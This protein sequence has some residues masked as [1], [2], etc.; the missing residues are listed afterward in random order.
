MTTHYKRGHLEMEAPSPS[1]QAPLPHRAQQG[2]TPADPSRTGPPSKRHCIRGPASTVLPVQGLPS[3]E[4]GFLASIDHRPFDPQSLHPLPFVPDALYPDATG[5]VT[6][7][8][9][10]CETGCLGRV[11][12]RPDPPQISQIPHLRLK[13]ETIRLQRSPVWAQYQPT[14][15]HSRLPIPAA[16][17]P[18]TRGQHSGLLGRLARLAPSRIPLRTGRYLSSK[19]PVLARVPHQRAQICP[20]PGAPDHLPRC[21][22]ER[23]IG[24]HSALGGQSLGNDQDRPPF[25]VPHLL[26]NPRVSGA[27]GPPQFRS[28]S[29]TPRSGATYTVLASVSTQTHTPLP[30]SPFSPAENPATGPKGLGHAAPACPSIPLFGGRSRSPPPDLDRRVQRRLECGHVLQRNCQRHLVCNPGAPTY[31]GKGNPCGSP[32]PSTPPSHQANGPFTHRLLLDGSSVQEEGLITFPSSSQTFSADPVSLQ[33]SPDHAEGVP[34]TGSPQH[35]GRLPIPCTPHTNRL[36]G[37][38]HGTPT[39]LPEARHPSDRSVCPSGKRQTITV[40]RAAPVPSGSGS[41]RPRTGLESVGIGLPVSSGPTPTTSPTETPNVSGHR[42]HNSPLAS[43][44]DVVDPHTSPRLSARTTHPTQSI[45]PGWDGQQA[46]F[47]AA[48]L[49]RV[50]FLTKYI[51]RSMEG[52]TSPAVTTALISSQRKS[53]RSQYQYA[54]AHFQAWLSSASVTQLNKA[55]V[56]GYLTHLTVSEKLSP[57]TAMVYRAA[58]SLPLLYGFGINTADREFSLLARSAFIANPPAQKPFPQWSLDKVLHL[59]RSAPYSKKPVNRLFLL[60]R[61]LFLLALASGNRVSE[62]AAIKRSTILFA[63]DR[64]SATL[65]VEEGFLYKNQ[66]PNRNPHP[67]KILALVQ[68]NTRHALCP[69]AALERWLRRTRKVHPSFVWGNPRTGNRLNRGTIA[70]L[71]CHLIKKADPGSIPHAHDVRKVAASLAWCRG[72]P[73]PTILE[74]AFWGSSNVFANHYL[75]PTNPKPGACVALGSR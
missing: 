66:R 42:D 17:G 23:P 9:L 22:V 37:P 72:V 10:V 14:S 29:P 43:R 3:P 75:G 61:T 68:N 25:P 74:R 18:L 56:L 35:V 41:G 4:T 26:H 67:I 5:T 49:S 36:V 28:A 62:I 8:N 16:S 33:T 7:D 45:H 71:I 51:P 69:V 38:V 19:H 2:L 52:E 50:D 32:K 20:H 70:K 54:W 65:Y 55:A 39:S 21:S 57:K 48:S 63:R 1:H 73:L 47:D 44:R 27:G 30:E 40:L 24:Q 59:L 60:Q 53:T 34:H 11:S 15:V 64:S 58:I 46:T 31:H 12:P 6:Q 13:R